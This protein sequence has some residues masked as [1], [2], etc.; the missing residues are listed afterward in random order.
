MKKTIW[1]SFVFFLA[2]ACTGYAQDTDA[3]MS[4][5][6]EEVEDV[7]TVEQTLAVETE[8][9]SDDAEIVEQRETVPFIDLSKIDWHAS[10]SAKAETI[11]TSTLRAYDDWTTV[12]MP[13]L[14]DLNASQSIC[15]VCLPFVEN[16]PTD[17]NAQQ[18]I[19][20]GGLK[21]N[22]QVRLNGNLFER[23]REPV[24]LESKK[25]E[26]L[27]TGRGV[28]N[29]IN[30]ISISVESNATSKM[31]GVQHNVYGEHGNV[32]YNRRLGFYS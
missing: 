10:V 9:D 24:S 26:C 12:S 13:S 14:F 22:C 6:S 31:H 5:S 18:L 20:I 11:S 2:L 15:L 1:L 21:G 7:A 32:E 27:Y 28:I 3:K 29:G 23:V 4:L 8:E 30:I 19:T 17:E 16:A 25:E